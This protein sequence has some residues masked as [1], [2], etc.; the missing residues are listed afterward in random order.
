MTY[1]G[2]R[3]TAS[4]TFPE[5]SAPY[6][7]WSGEPSS[8]GGSGE[9]HGGGEPG[10]PEVSHLGWGHWYAHKELPAAPVPTSNA[11]SQSIPA[12]QASPATLGPPWSQFAGS[13][14]YM[15][16]PMPAVLYN[17][18]PRAPLRPQFDSSATNSA[19]LI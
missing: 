12:N 11:S 9:S 13:P 7:Q 19:L 2:L 15:C 6:H 3:A 5:Q 17:V 14:A 4:I 18:L 10:V 1:T 8:R 16:P